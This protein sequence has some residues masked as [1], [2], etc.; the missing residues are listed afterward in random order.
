MHMHTH[1]V[2]QCS[3][4]YSVN[5]LSFFILFFF[6]IILNYCHICNIATIL[7]L[8]Q[9]LNSYTDSKFLHRNFLQST[10]KDEKENYWMLQIPL[11][12]CQNIIEFITFIDVLS[13]SKR[14]NGKSEGMPRYPKS[15]HACRFYQTQTGRKT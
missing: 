4:I 3:A 2:V 13:V 9:L 8:H 5:H 14:P 6:W 11:S 15:R 12:D 10:K 7:F 1:V